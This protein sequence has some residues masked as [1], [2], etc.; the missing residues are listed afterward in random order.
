MYAIDIS[1]PSVSYVAI[2]FQFYYLS[3]N[4]VYEN[5]C[6]TK[7]V[8]FL[9]LIYFYVHDTRYGFSFTSFQMRSQLYLLF[10]L[11]NSPFSYW[12]LTHASIQGVSPSSFNYFILL[13]FL[14]F[15]F[16]LPN[17]LHWSLVIWKL[18]SNWYALRTTSL[19]L[20]SESITIV[21]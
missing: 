16:P 10:L 7:F 9:I 19:F 15:S 20:S 4:F 12:R 1:L 21:W 6:Q 5:F 3:L 14:H 18:Y 13:Y 17:Q 8:N 2:L 11:N